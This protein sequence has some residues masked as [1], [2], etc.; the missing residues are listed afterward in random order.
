MILRPDRRGL[1]RAP[2]LADPRQLAGAS[3]RTAQTVGRPGRYGF[4]GG[5]P[6]VYLEVSEAADVRH[7]I[8]EVERP[9]GM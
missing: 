8:I 9:S 5:K 3:G 6:R 4:P 2:P 1:T 7:P